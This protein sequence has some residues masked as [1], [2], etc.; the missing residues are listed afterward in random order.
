[1]KNSNFDSE[2][3]RISAADAGVA[4]G[5]LAPDAGISTSAPIPPCAVLLIDKPA[6]YTSHD[7]VSRLRRLTGIK[8]IGHAGTLDPFATGLLIM[9]VGKATRLFDYFMPL[10]KEYLVKVQFGASSTTGDIDGKI[11]VLSDAASSEAESGPLVKTVTGALADPVVTEAALRDILPEFT[12]EI[13]QKAH[14]FSAVKVGGEALYKKARRGE[15]VEAPVRQVEITRLEL[16]SFDA[17]NQ[18][19]S[20]S[21]DCSKG[22]YIR[23]LVEDI[24]DRLGT[25]AYALELRRTRIGEYGLERASALKELAALPPDTLLT[26][27]NP[28]FISGLGALYFLPVREVDEIEARAVNN[29]RRLAGEADGPIRIACDGRILAIYGPC[30]KPGELRP[31]VVLA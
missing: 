2:S 10:G 12:G 19:A 4:G 8:K 28:S 20:L 5:M 13:Y 9:M 1:M 18:R 11:T 30:D 17:E 14:A 23:Q 25:A 21:V 6:G 16:E 7:V 22:T 29:G 15:A 31:L 26:D 27:A 24:A 3:G